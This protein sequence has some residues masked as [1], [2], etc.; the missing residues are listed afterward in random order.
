VAG[1]TWQGPFT[2]FSTQGGGELPGFPVGDEDRYEVEQAMVETAF[3]GRGLSWQQ[4]YHWK[5][6]EDTVSGRVTELQ[7]YYLQAG[8]FFNA[9]LKWV[10]RPL[11]LAVRWA[12]VDSNVAQDAL[13]DRIRELTFAANWFFAGHRNKLTLDYSLLERKAAD[14]SE[15]RERRLRIQWDVSF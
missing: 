13:D 7:G 8:Y 15:R 9:F 4:E 3:Q 11:E 5:R 14:P 1:A 6:V 10:P 2:A 12:E